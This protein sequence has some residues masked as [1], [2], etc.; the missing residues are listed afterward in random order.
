MPF[1]SVSDLEMSDSRHPLLMIHDATH[2]LL[3]SLTGFP[4]FSPP[5]QS[6]LESRT[7]PHLAPLPLMEDIPSFLSRRVILSG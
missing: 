1:L 2:V 3:M 6:R 5:F 4:V 7:H